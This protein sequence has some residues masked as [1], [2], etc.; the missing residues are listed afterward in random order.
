MGERTRKSRLGLITAFLLAAVLHFALSRVPS[1]LGMAAR[2]TRQAE[3]EDAIEI[4]RVPDNDPRKTVV[5]TSKAKDDPKAKDAP[6]RYGAEVRNR[7]AKETQSSQKGRFQEGR[8]AGGAS[9]PGVEDPNGEPSAPKLKDLLAYGASPN[10]FPDDIAQ[11]NQT[12]LNTDPVKYASFINRIADEVYD[13]WVT[14]ARDAVRTIYQLGRKLE[15]NT[16][17]TKIR[18]V[19]DETGEVRAIQTLKSSGV[20]E[21]DDAPKKAFWEVEP[22][23][24]PPSQ[25]F[26]KDG[27]IRF[28]YEFHFEW[29]TSS[30]NIV[31]FS[32]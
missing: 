5:Q 27:L 17:I 19:M 3:D 14:L 30:F 16:Y 21:L 7:V 15:A 12:L 18:V 13:P 32:I 31:P 20:A 29:R 26:E 22:F 8:T 24:H 23:P 10:D 28:T 25:M 1:P 9:L 4:S 11:G 2:F 6:A